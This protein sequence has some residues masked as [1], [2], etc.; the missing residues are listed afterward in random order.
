M[1]SAERLNALCELP[2]ISQ[3]DVIARAGFSQADYFRGA[4]REIARAA[5]VALFSNW[6][7]GLAL[8]F[9]A[10]EHAQRTK[11]TLLRLGDPT[12]S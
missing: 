12:I 2:N 4:R 11:A 8:V 7:L 1:W 10:L 6:P 3:H 5:V 9:L